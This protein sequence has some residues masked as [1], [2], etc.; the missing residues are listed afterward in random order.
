[1][2]DARALRSGTRM[3]KIKS[4]LFVAVLSLFGCARQKKLAHEPV[5]EDPRWAQV[6]SL[7]EKGLYAS[8]LD[9]S[10]EI[11]A[12]ARSAGDPITTFKAQQFRSRYR[13]LT[14]E[15]PAQVIREQ[16]AEL[17]GLEAD[18]TDNFPLP[19]LMHSVL[20][21]SYWTLYQQDRWRILDRTRIH[22]PPAD[23]DDISTWDQHR[24][25]QAVV[26]HYLA[27]LRPF[28]LLKD[29]PAVT[30]APLIEWPDRTNRSATVQDHVGGSSRLIDILA[31]RALS[32]LINPETTITG[33]RERY[34]MDDPALFQLFEP[35]AFHEIG[36][37]DTL[38]WQYQALRIYQQWERA[39][40]A[41]D[42][43]EALVDITLSRLDHVRSNSL[44]AEKDSLYREALIM[45]RS[46]VENSPAWSEVTVALA[47]WHAERGDRFQRLAPLEFKWEKR[48]AV[49]FAR[50]AME[51]DPGSFGARKAGQLLD[52]ITSPGLDAQVE[53][54]VL[55]EKPFIVAVGFRNVDT[56]WVRVVRDDPA[57]D[58][59]YGRGRALADLLTR[60]QVL[61]WPVVMPDDGDH[62]RHL[63]ELPVE[64]LPPGKYAIILSTDERMRLEQDHI[65][66]ASFW[67]T[68]ISMA[69]R[70]SE[71]DME[72]V[73]LDRWT[74]RPLEGAA[75]ALYTMHR[76]QGRQQWMKRNEAT[77][78]KE[79]RIR[80]DHPDKRFA[81]RWEITLG[82]DRF[83]SSTGWGYQHDGPYDERQ[84]TRT[85]LFT[86]RAIYRPGQRIHFKG[87]T[88]AQE[89]GGAKVLPGRSSTI[90]LYDVNGQ[91]VDSLAFVTDRFGSFHGSFPAPG[92]LTGHMRIEV[93]DG[94]SGFMVEEY[95]RPR[96]EVLMDTLGSAK[97]LN[98]QVVVS[99]VARSYSGVELDGAQVKWVVKRMMRFPWWSRGQRLGLP[100]PQH[101]V[102]VANGTTTTDGH[103]RFQITFKAAPDP[104]FP[105]D[106]DPLFMF[107][108][109]A[110]VTDRSGE[111]QGGST[112]LNIGY[113]SIAIEIGLDAVLDRSVSR[114]MDVR[115]NDLDGSPVVLPAHVRIH[116]LSPPS[117]PLRER[118]WE[119]PDRPLLTRDEH[120]AIFP[121]DPFTQEDDPLLW[122]I[123][124]TVLHLDEWHRSDGAIVLNDVQDWI[125]G[126]Y[127]IEVEATDPFGQRVVVRKPITVVD[128]DI[129]N[130]GFNYRM[131]HVIKAD[132]ERPLEPG[133]KARFLISSGVEGGRIGMEV[134]RDGRIAI[135]RWFTLEHGQ[136]L[137]ELPVQED[138]RGGFAVHFIGTLNG[139][140][141]RTT[142][143]VEVPWTNKELQVEWITFR[144]EALPGAQ[145]EYRLRIK[146]PRGGQ[147]AAQIL[148][149]MYDASLDRYG[150]HAWHMYQW[151]RYSSRREWSRMSPFNTIH[152]SSHFPKATWPS[153]II[154]AHPRLKTFGWP[155]SYDQAFFMGRHA[156]GLEMQAMMVADDTDMLEERA[157][158]AEMRTEVDAPPA[159]AIRAD[160][161]ETAFFLPDLQTDGD[162]SVVFRA[163]L[164]EALTRWKL[165]GLAHTE[166]LK[167]AQFQREVVTRKPLMVVPNLPRT[168]RVG[169]RITLTTR[170]DALEKEV[171]GTASIELFDPRTNQ[172]IN[173]R[174]LFGEAEHPFTAAP[175]ASGIAAW[176]LEVPE[177]LDMIGMRV[178][179][180]GGE[181]I[182]DGEEHVLP[183]LSS[184]LLVTESLPIAVRRAGTHKARLE[185][186]LSDT[187]S[188]L[189]HH[190]LMVEFTPVPAW[191]AVQALPY[192]AEF[193]Y[194]CSE[195]IFSRY[196][197]N[198]L[199][200]HIVAQR[201]G[202]RGIMEEWRSELASGEDPFQSALERNARLK[203]IML[204]ETPWLMRSR[205]DR[206]RRMDLILLFDQDRL[207]RE[208]AT[209]LEKLKA[210]RLPDGSWPWFNGMYPSRMITQHIVAGFG[211]LEKLGATTQASGQ[212]RP[213]LEPAVTWLD[214]QVAEWHARLKD[215]SPAEELQAHRPSYAEIHYLYARSFHKQVPVEPAAMEAMAFIRE[216]VAANWLDHALQEQVMIALALHRMDVPEV[217]ADILRSLSERATRSE[218]LGMYWRGFTPGMEWHSFPT[219]THALAIEAFHEILDEKQIA[220]ELRM[221]LLKLKH[222][223]DWGTTK[224]TAQACYALLLTG[225]DLLE[226][227]APPLISVGGEHVR[228]KEQESGTGYFSQVWSGNDVGA[229]MGEVIIQ[230]MEDRLAWGA[231]HWRY[232]EDMDKIT[233]HA[234][235]GSGTPFTLRKQVL[236]LERDA[237]GTRLVPL[238]RATPITPGDKLVVRL[239][240]T[241]DRYVDHVHLK[242]LRASGLEPVEVLSG[243]R[244]QGGL[245]HY[246]SVRDASMNYFFDRIPPGTHVF[247][248]ELHVTHKGEFSNGITTAM[249]M[250]AP[251]FN[252]HSAGQRIMVGE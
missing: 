171:S 213:M 2:I 223:T 152:A 246:Q 182:G 167:I 215:S 207:A 147:V 214:R 36:S 174:A 55:P 210:L 126:P 34:T 188:T 13:L 82:E 14:G 94:S 199:S 194:D 200:A 161:R 21:E 149:S 20:A 26:H 220:D 232:F 24:Y 218:E 184:K 98:E 240:L 67:S 52:Q 166:D 159:P 121:L 192:L 245:I 154:R 109:E 22:A 236:R 78:D 107:M 133:G 198:R 32:V 47:K 84:S 148:T 119:R 201:P 173:D 183:V 248:Y 49:E 186:L 203:T 33:P 209:T 181:G 16:E 216:R 189:R 18:T 172:V 40:L 70:N 206:Q 61:S 165:M 195:Q 132:D 118:K 205:D 85:F 125:V 96:F 224:A 103:G 48:T 247:E 6:D 51:H 9:L 68:N 91:M 117:R 162:G 39:H 234:E 29:M 58:E 176:E 104:A 74:G 217:P 204:E 243:P 175:G 93:E 158:P 122:P 136:Q 53:E 110:E 111:T 101:P 138:D 50:A 178:M 76:D 72:L 59:E 177:G 163:T 114:T 105:R 170:I 219:E 156:G 252:A 7:D 23:D 227:V 97:R 164:P 249:C 241:T 229:A 71:R 115:I 65:V 228:P 86:D 95:K 60:E 4:L 31:R 15:E 25:M 127:L 137:I 139:R 19:Q 57:A 77:A 197:A 116:R 128:P 151:P 92:G 191:H 99:G 155:D 145:E 17:R 230:T 43:P 208:E 212:F 106:S 146:G 89:A 153:D 45:L 102:E 242:D 211:H 123:D 27:S 41:D 231:L 10:R 202:I 131:L 37:T 54:A 239:E 46:R 1:M 179:A 56:V 8:A 226:E 113:Q 144:S 73:L 142:I 238:D 129:Q 80:M 250:Y 100:Y 135:S 38:A 75:A 193:P 88:T 63:T 42:G 11:L 120:T 87:I 169:D 69:E 235:R 140:Q 237:S 62:H 233:A 134:E 12:D 83:S 28:E 130:T 143:P 112:S 150:P 222:T 90:R 79:G 81:Y 141:L 168:L 66:H 64:G 124:T 251:E 180:L 35:F 157:P 221:Y 44:L 244:W 225:R 30:I 5:R 190:S 196:Y 160:L 187:S 108:V 3:M 185:K